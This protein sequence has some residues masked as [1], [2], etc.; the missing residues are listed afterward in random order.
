MIKW[1]KI[2]RGS[3]KFQFLNCLNTYTHTHFML[4]G[5]CACTY[6]HTHTH[7]SEELCASVCR[8][9]EPW[10]W[11][12]QVPSECCKLCAR[13]CTSHHETYFIYQSCHHCDIL[14]YCKHSFGFWPCNADIIV[15][16]IKSSC[17]LGGAWYSFLPEHP[18]SW[19]Q[20]FTWLLSCL[21][22]ARRVSRSTVPTS[23][24]SFLKSSPTINPLVM[25]GFKFQPLSRAMEF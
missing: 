25:V 14:R 17:N 3:L 2:W 9:E 21:T 10:R 19:L 24:R 22:N 12:Q 16:F 6:T 8:V 20:D 13:L 15:R 11:M 1:W 4:S 7:F 18:R 23:F 5:M